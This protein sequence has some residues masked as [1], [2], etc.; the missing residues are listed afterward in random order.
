MLVSWLDKISITTNDMT[1]EGLA[2]LKK[3]LRKAIELQVDAVL[4][5]GTLQSIYCDEYSEIDKDAEE[6][7]FSATNLARTS[8]NFIMSLEDE[9]QK[10]YGIE[11]GIESLNEQLGNKQSNDEE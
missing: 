8:L 3:V 11:K 4:V 6:T 10:A 5:M 9:I 2:N 1:T 7:L